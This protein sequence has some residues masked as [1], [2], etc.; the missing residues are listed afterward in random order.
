MAEL[1]WEMFRTLFLSVLIFL[2]SADISKRLVINQEISFVRCWLSSISN[3]GNSELNL[4]LTNALQ[5]ANKEKSLTESHSH[6]K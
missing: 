6:Q 4:G 5:K 3:K 1:V 2:R